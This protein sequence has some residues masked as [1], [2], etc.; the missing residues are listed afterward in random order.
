MGLKFKRGGGYLNEV[1]VTI[2]GYQWTVGDEATIKKGSRKGETFTPLS[3]EPEFL[4]DGEDEPKTQRLLLGDA[5]GYGEVTDDGA[6][7]QTPDG[8]GIGERSEVGIFLQS[9]ISGGFDGDLFGDDETAID[10]RPMIGA[11]VRLVQEV[12]VEKT[13]RQGKQQGKDGKE[14]D[15]R[16]LK[17]ATFHGMAEAAPKAKAGAKPAAGK[18]AP[19]GKKEPV[20]DIAEL[21]T[22]TLLEILSEQKDNSIAKSKLSMAILKKLNKDANREAVREWLFDDDNLEGIDGVDYNKKKGTLTVSE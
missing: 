4:V 1:D 8:Q 21:A 11:R 16:D 9:L 2:V 5:N 15:R 13:K 7:L 18:D 17:V 12:N 6:V 3:L 10:L 22:A 20:V 19:K 14:Y